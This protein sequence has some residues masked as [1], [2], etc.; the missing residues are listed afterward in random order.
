[1]KLTY[2][3]S[4][5][6][7]LG[8]LSCSSDVL[9]GVQGTVKKDVITVVSKHPG[10]I[11]EIRFM[12][13]QIAEVGD[14]LAVIDVPEIKAKMHQA[15]GAVDA[16]QAQYE[17]ATNGATNDQMNQIKAKLNA[18]TEQYKFAQKSFSRI[19]AMYKDSLVS[20][21]KYDEVYMK[22]QG[23]KSQ[24]EGVK[25]KY[26]EVKNGVRSEKVRMAYGTLERAE[27]ALQEAQIA[28]AD[29]YLIAPRQMEIQTIALGEGE[30][31]LPGYGIFTAYIPNSTYFRFTIA[32]SRVNEVKIN[33]VMEVEN[34]FTKENFKAK[35]SSIKQL[36]SYADRSTPFPNYELGEAIYE[37][38]LLPVDVE[39]ASKLYANSRVVL[40]F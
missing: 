17:M 21:Q 24:Y 22:Y 34:P 12:E 26:D 37:I 5:T 20:S 28:D 35:I 38:K 23:A 33:D 13:S 18:V 36:T 6:V 29:R 19:K 27:G 10:H 2:F 32:E 7:L 1:M 9:N 39:K 14:T 16:A 31:A 3:L 40:K 30:L 8:L 11:S 15:Q 4:A 25:A